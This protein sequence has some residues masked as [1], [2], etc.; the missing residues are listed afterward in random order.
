MLQ[1]KTSVAI[2][3]LFGAVAGSAVIAHVVTRYSV[4]V[5]CPAPAS[6]AQQ[7]EFFKARPVPLGDG[8]RF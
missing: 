2:L 6:S 4:Q 8:E 7:S 5:T 1:L 3:I